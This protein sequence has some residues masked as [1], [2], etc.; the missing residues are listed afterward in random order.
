MSDHVQT[1]YIT[2]GRRSLKANYFATYHNND[3]S[4]FG[5]QLIKLHCF[6]HMFYYTT[7]C[8]NH[9]DIK[10]ASNHQKVMKFQGLYF[11]VLIADLVSGH[12]I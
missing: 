12:L 10:K 9:G 7:M 3:V 11:C 8:S 4:I 6:V 1:S 5:M 2:A